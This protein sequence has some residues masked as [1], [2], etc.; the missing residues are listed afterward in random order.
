MELKLKEYRIINFEDFVI[1]VNSLMVNFDSVKLWWRGQADSDWK[2]TPG[3]FRYGKANRESNISVL[4][5]M[6]AKARYSNCPTSDDPFPW[7]FLMQHYRLPTRLLDWTESPLVA[8]YF[9]VENEKDDDKDSVIWALQPS[10]LNSKQVQQ[11]KILSPGNVEVRPLFKEAFK[12][13]DNNPDQRIVAILT[14]QCD[15]RQLVQQSEFTIHGSPVPMEN[16]LGNEQ[17][18]GKILIPSSEKE[19]FRMML[20]H[21]GLSRS[22]LFPDLENLSAELASLNFQSPVT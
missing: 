7:L 1:A 21:F 18:L 22:Y 9:A 20:D 17:F 19:K 6:K 15:I 4:F 14:E 5:R 12:I 13:N 10:L 8:L 3:I 11:N 2:L 16:L